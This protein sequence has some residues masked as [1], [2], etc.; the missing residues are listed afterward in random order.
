MRQ[1]HAALLVGLLAAASPA[2]QQSSGSVSES[3]ASIDFQRRVTAYAALRD[4]LHE[5]PAKLPETS[6]PDRIA[7]AE[8][9]LQARIQAARP[10]VKAGDIFT[11]NIRALFRRLL[12]PEVEGPRGANTRGS[13]QDEAPGEFPF[14][15]NGVYPKEQPLGSV[16]PNI[17]GTLP[18]LPE[19]LEYRFIG[20]H[21]ILR[22]VRA[23]L[24][25]D[26]IPHAIP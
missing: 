8:R 26:Y 15:V 14:Q 16:P 12:V 11:P 6:D 5:G 22:D 24:I 3:D 1:L 17:L 18:R 9:A 10:G 19:H 20:K 13:L 4:K 7:A 21:L 23:N 25:V 2:A